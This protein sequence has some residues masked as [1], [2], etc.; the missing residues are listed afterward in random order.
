MD[1]RTILK[2]IYMVDC[3]NL[4]QG[5]DRWYV[6]VNMDIKFQGPQK[7]GNFLTS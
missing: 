7:V 3:I 6:L 5:R 1:G 2:Q 4:A